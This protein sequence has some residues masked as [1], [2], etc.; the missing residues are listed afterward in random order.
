[1]IPC[2]IE[3]RT[4][5]GEHKTVTVDYPRGHVENPMTDAEIEGKFRGLAD[6]ALARAQVD[7]GLDA[8]WEMEALETLEPIFGALQA[9]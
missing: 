1:M 8:L 7:S 6:R 3:V 4:T 9:P 2:R 5:S